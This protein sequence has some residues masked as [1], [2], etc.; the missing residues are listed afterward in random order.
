MSERTVNDNSP[1]L[2]FI[3]SGFILEYVGEKGY[4]RP[5][6]EIPALICFAWII[7]ELQQES[8]KG[9]VVILD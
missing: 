2:S 1:P 6:E 7:K 3:L 9:L 4:D 5:G 8:V